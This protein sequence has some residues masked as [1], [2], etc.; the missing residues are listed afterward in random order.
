MIVSNLDGEFGTIVAAVGFLLFINEWIGPADPNTCKSNS[1]PECL[2]RGL[3]EALIEFIGQAT[4]PK[5]GTVGAIY[6]FRNQEVMASLEFSNC[7]PPHIHTRLK[8]ILATRINHEFSN[9]VV[10]A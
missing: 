8:K 3:I 4:G 2:S 1:Y 10:P 5:D 9:T 6:E 7:N